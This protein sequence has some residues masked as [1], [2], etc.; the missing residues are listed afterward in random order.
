M[1]HPLFRP[2]LF[3]Q[4]LHLSFQGLL[5]PFFLLQVAP[6]AL[7]NPTKQEPASPGRFR[8]Y[9]LL[10]AL[11][12]CSLSSRQ[13]DYEVSLK[14]NSSALYTLL[15]Q[16]HGGKVGGMK[17]VPSQLAYSRYITY[18]IARTTSKLCPSLVP[19]NFSIAIDRTTQQL[20]KQLGEPS[21]VVSPR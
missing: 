4:F 21:S 9:L 17:T 6:S 20:L 19:K 3:S 12:T 14:A 10:T 11:S 7:S 2:N 8:S 16:L 18:Q 13:I 15:T 5:L 1:I